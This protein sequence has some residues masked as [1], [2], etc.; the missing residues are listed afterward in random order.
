MRRAASTLDITFGDILLNKGYTPYVKEGFRESIGLHTCDKRS[1]RTLL[2][3]TYRTSAR[4][5]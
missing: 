5:S 2:Q 3:S 1:N 4:R